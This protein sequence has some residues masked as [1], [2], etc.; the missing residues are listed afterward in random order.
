MSLI[1]TPGGWPGCGPF[2]VNPWTR[3]LL[4]QQLL[5]DTIDLLDPFLVRTS[6][7]HRWRLAPIQYAALPNVREGEGD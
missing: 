2:P 7:E 5:V 1:A 4:L 3:L 6:Q